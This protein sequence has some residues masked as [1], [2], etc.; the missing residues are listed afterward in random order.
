MRTPIS[1]S[2]MF[3][4]ASVALVF[5]TRFC[6]KKQHLRDAQLTFGH[7]Y[8]IIKFEHLQKLILQSPKRE[9]SRRTISQT[10]IERYSG[11]L[12]PVFENTDF[13][14]G[15]KIQHIGAFTLQLNTY[16]FRTKLKT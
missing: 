13:R 2:T 8:H 5:S 11:T 16:G 7:M 15:N 10:N 1:P 3:P 4:E 9:K 6:T 12:I 14:K